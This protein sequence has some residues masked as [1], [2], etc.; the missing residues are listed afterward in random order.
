RWVMPPD[1]PSGSVSGKAL[2][3][4]RIVSAVP[5]LLLVMSGVMKLLKPDS[6]VEGFTTLGW[7]ER[8]AL[9]LGIL[10]LTCAALCVIPRTSVMGAILLTGFLGGAIATHVRIGDLSILPQVVLGVLVWL[11][12]YLRVAGLRALVPLRS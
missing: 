10:Q 12:L 7:P 2:W 11:G 8:F 6:V 1:P 3:A 5:A 4:G 9:G